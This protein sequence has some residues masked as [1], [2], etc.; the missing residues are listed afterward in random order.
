MYLNKI[1]AFLVSATTHKI[2]ILFNKL[3]LRSHLVPVSRG[4]RPDKSSIP[5]APNAPSLE[6]E[7]G[8]EYLLGTGHGDGGIRPQLPCDMPP[9]FKDFTGAMTTAVHACLLE[10]LSVHTSC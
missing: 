9:A 3:F 1:S 7:A 5:C 4:V 6:E 10:R 2:M 8:I